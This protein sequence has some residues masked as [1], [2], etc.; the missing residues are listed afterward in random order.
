MS[1]SASQTR[2]VE[3]LLERHGQTYS[4]EAGISLGKGTPA[5][6][7]QLLCLATLLSARIR[8]EAAVSASRALFDEGLTTVDKMSGSTWERRTRILNRSGYAR[9]DESTSR[10]LGDTAEL[11]S[12]RYGGDLRNL[13]QAAE[14]DPSRERKL[15]KEC[16][17][18]G[19]V[20]VNIF[21]REVQLLWDEVHPFADDAVLEA[22]RDL[23][24]PA[25]PD[26]LAKLVSTSE[27]P[28]L[29][30]ALVRSRLASDADEV[31][32]EASG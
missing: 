17:G 8:A 13:R 31:L 30:A 24:L 16:K 7:Y 23:Q 5:P 6:L 18:I 32:A 12:D 22:A 9:Y 14:R 3:T 15:L 21:F 4:D 27:F 25:K 26:G 10:M 19:D 2:T 11:L 20:G 1:P 28:V 29:A